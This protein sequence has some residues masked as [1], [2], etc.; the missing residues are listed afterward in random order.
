MIWQEV[1]DTL[2]KHFPSPLGERARERGVTVDQA[3]TQ[4]SYLP[5]YGW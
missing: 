5:L 4:N 3:I 2:K 1:F